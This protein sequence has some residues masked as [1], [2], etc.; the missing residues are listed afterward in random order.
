MLYST[1][2]SIG[3]SQLNRMLCTQ[4]SVDKQQSVTAVS[5]YNNLHIALGEDSL[6]SIDELPS[7]PVLAHSGLEH[8]QV[9]TF[10]GEFV[11]ALCTREETYNNS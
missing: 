5:T 1:H 10:E 2:T 8:D 3:Y 9:S 11:H 7:E 4:T 6:S